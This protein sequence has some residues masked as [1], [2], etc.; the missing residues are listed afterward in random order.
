MKTQ[1]TKSP[2]A[3]SEKPNWKEIA[4]FLAQQV[5]FAITYLAPKSGSGMILNT[6]TGEMQHWRERFAEAMERIPGITVDREALYAFDLPAK[7]RRKFFKDRAA[8]A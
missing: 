1:K 7:E 5:N 8:K 6:N 4:L 3:R 2:A